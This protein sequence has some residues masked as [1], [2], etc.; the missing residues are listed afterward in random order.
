MLPLVQ[1]YLFAM[2]I[3]K[4]VIST[5]IHI[6]IQEGVNVGIHKLNLSS[7]LTLLLEQQITLYPH[8][9]ANNDWIIV[10]GMVPDKKPEDNSTEVLM[11]SINYIK[12]GLHF[13]LPPV[14]LFDLELG[15]D[16]NGSV[17]N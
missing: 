13:S 17:D 1:Q 8:Q 3:P 6:T 16:L 10:P 11:S 14:L 15:A 9:D 12:P 7:F 4:A 2:S 5:L